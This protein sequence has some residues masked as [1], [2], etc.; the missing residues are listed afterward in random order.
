MLAS[1]R[2]ER[3][4]LSSNPVTQL[5]AHPKSV[6]LLTSLITNCTRQI[7]IH[8]T[9]IYHPSFNM[10]FFISTLAILAAS[11]TSTASSVRHGLRD[12]EEFSMT[13]DA[14]EEMKKGSGSKKSKC[15]PE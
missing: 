13:F 1:F 15:G 14:P 9:V 5:N 12:L 8:F 11:S 10:N 3:K 2:K 6:S 7:A 4:D